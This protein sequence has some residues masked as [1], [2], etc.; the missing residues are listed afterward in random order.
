MRWTCDCG[1]QKDHAHFLCKHLVQAAGPMDASWWVQATRYHI[2]PFYTIPVNGVMGRAPER[3]RD[4]IWMARMVPPSAIVQRPGGMRPIPVPGANSDGDVE[5]PDP[6]DDEFMSSSSISSLPGKA[7]PTG[8]DGLF[9]TRAGGGAGFELEDEDEV[10]TNE[11]EHLLGKA[12]TF[13]AEQEQYQDPLFLRNAKKA[14]RVSIQWVLKST[15][16][17]E[18][19]TTGLQSANE[20]EWS[21][22]DIQRALLCAA[23]LIRVLS[24]T[25]DIEHHVSRHTMPK[26]NRSRTVHGN[27][28]AER[29]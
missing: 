4:H 13:L 17:P 28:Y 20:Q 24:W 5:I 21:I 27:R 11:V 7:R 18:E 29:T 10:C 19:W 3:M 26:T 14:V 15:P 8:Q 16:G 2:P 22:R 25:R 1:S 12:I 23:E 6:E 9:R